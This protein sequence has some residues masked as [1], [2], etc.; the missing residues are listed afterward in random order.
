MEDIVHL[1]LWFEA[2]SLKWS[3]SIKQQSLVL[4]LSKILVENIVLLHNN[5]CITII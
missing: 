4:F 5:K 2:N 3:L 1:C